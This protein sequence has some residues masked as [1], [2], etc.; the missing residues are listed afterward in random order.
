M[1]PRNLVAL[2]VVL[3]VPALLALAAC[4]GDDDGGGTFQPGRLTDPD[5]VPTATP[6]EVPPEV[7][8]LDPDNIA[9]LPPDS[10]NSGGASPTTS[11]AAGEPGICGDTYTVIAGDTAFGIGEKCGWPAEDLANFVSLLQELNPDADP[12]NLSVGQVLTMPQPEGDSEEGQ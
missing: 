7:V 8:L 6:W 12:A 3:L 2:C 11:P 10:P 4:G 5:R 1:P 9:P